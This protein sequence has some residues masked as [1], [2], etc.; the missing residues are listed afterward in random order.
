MSDLGL[1]FNY[2]IWSAVY[3][4]QISGFD[5]FVWS[6]M[7]WVG[8]LIVQVSRHHLWWEVKM[9][10]CKQ[11]SMKWDTHNIGFFVIPLGVLKGRKG[12][13]TQKRKDCG[14]YCAAFLPSTITY[15]LLLKLSMSL[16]KPSKQWYHCWNFCTALYFHFRVAFSSR[17][18]VEFLLINWR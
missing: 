15:I 6:V 18:D 14:H 8:S 4:D 17:W 13:R 9:E 5:Y 2:A 10:R 16:D 3:T 7:N 12:K 11:V 1:D